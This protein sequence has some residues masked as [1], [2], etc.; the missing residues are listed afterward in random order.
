MKFSLKPC[1]KSLLYLSNQCCEILQ[2]YIKPKTKKGNKVVKNDFTKAVSQDFSKTKKK[3][4]NIFLKIGKKL[5]RAEI[6]K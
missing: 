4:K 3:K 1:L 2:K 5:K 6:E